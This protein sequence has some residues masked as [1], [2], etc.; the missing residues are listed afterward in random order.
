MRFDKKLKISIASSIAEFVFVNLLVF[1]IPFPH[2]AIFW[3]AYAFLMASIVVNAVVIYV[4]ASEILLP[5][6][7]ISYYPL[8]RISSIYLIVQGIVSLIFFIADYYMPSILVWIPLVLSLIIFG[9]A[10]G[11]IIA[12]HSGIKIVEEVGEKTKEEISFITNLMAET[13]ILRRQVLENDLKMKLNSLYETVRFSDPVSSPVLAD[14]EMR[15]R[16]E[17]NILKA[18]VTLQE[19]E[20]AIESIQKLTALIYERNQKCKLSK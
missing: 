9:I 1:L 13:E 17:L 16:D 15:I 3:S 14:V 7:G 19:T 11:L 20:K 8:L 10:V 18:T 2:G 5:K 12:A 4:S 6:K